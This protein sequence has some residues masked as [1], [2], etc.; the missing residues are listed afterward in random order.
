M[1]KPLIAC[2][3]GSCN[4]AH[5]SEIGLAEL[6]QCAQWVMFSGGFEC[7]EECEDE[8]AKLG[9]G[10]YTTPLAELYSQPFVNAEAQALADLIR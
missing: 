10:V 7:G 4:F 3:R 1:T 6:F 5:N 2:F 8:M 9:A